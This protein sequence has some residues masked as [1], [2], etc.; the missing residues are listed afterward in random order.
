MTC[1]SDYA[2]LC[3]DDENLKDTLNPYMYPTR[4]IITHEGHY[5]GIAT[6]YENGIKIKWE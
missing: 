5:N 2:Y 1:T 4:I 6:I 3:K